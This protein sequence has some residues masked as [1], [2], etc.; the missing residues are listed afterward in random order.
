MEFTFSIQ[1]IIKQSLDYLVEL[2]ELPSNP[3]ANF[4]IK[5]PLF[6]PVVEKE[7]E[8]EV[9]SETEEQQIKEYA[10]QERT[11]GYPD[12]HQGY[13]ALLIYAI[14]QHP[15]CMLSLSRMFTSCNVAT[16]VLM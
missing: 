3:Y 6:T 12:L 10:L 14:I 11:P 4:K 9:F 16:G 15:S 5:A 7:P 2:G 1:L 8:Y 13:V